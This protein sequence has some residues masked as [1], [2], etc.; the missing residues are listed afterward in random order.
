M[1][2]GTQDLSLEIQI[3]TNMKTYKYIQNEQEYKKALT[4]G[5]FWE[6]YPMLTGIWKEDEPLIKATIFSDNNKG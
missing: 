1:H 3:V 4:S 5:M 2:N 6:W